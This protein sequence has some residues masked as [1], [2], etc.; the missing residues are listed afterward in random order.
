MLNLIWRLVRNKIKNR[1][2]LVW[3]ISWL[4]N[5]WN[6]EI[7]ALLFGMISK[8]FQNKVLRIERLVSQLNLRTLQNQ[9]I[10][11]QINIIFHFLFTSLK[12]KKTFFKIPK[13]KGQVWGHIGYI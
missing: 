7:R 10:S 9:K 2:E 4:K 1:E 5:R 13:S 8:I 6:Y 12:G 3:T 11:I